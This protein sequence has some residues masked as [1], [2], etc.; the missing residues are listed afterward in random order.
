M[1][2]ENGEPLSNVK[3]T[4]KLSESDKTTKYV[5]ALPAFIDDRFLDIKNDI[6]L[7]FWM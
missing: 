6:L 7:R 4:G 1:E 2:V 3:L 5:T